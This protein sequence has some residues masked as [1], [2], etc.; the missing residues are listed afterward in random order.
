MEPAVNSKGNGREVRVSCEDEGA[1]GVEGIKGGDWFE[2]RHVW[3]H[4]MLLTICWT[5]FALT[6]VHPSCS[7]R[8]SAADLLAKQ[9]DTG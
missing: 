7:P 9:E 4:M 3:I 5:C 6:I 1:E 8:F 2:L